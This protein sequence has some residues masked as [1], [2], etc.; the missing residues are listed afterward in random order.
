M[1]NSVDFLF[2]YATFEHVPNVTAAFDE[3]VRVLRPGGYAWLAP[4]WNC[5]AWTVAKLLQRPY[6]ELSIM[7]KFGKLLIPI[8]EN[9]LVRLLQAMPARL[10]R[11]AS[12]AL[13]RPV[14]LEWRTLRP[15]F[16]LIDKYGHVSDDDAFVSMDAHAALTW[17]VGKAFQVLSH[18][19]IG[20]RLLV[21]SGPILVRKPLS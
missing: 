10:R 19:T 13:G 6:R 4:A 3:V 17:F 21:R 9:L 11:E 16:A 20:D 15:D 18:P 5:R 8:R 1:E 7:E 2:S 12:L 14:S